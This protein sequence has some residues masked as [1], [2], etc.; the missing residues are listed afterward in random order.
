MSSLLLMLIQPKPS[1]IGYV[2][3][4]FH[5]ITGDFDD[6]TY[7]GERYRR[8]SGGG[9]KLRPR[10]RSLKAEKYLQ[11]TIQKVIS[12]ASTNQIKI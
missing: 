11:S 9:L 3:I 1:N 8:G 2:L 5:I 10:R 6:P 12:I 7:D 4:S